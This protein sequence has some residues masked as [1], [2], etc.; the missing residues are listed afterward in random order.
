MNGVVGPGARPWPEHG[1]SRR[2]YVPVQPRLR[3]RT[4]LRSGAGNPTWYPLRDPTARF[5]YFAR[6]A[7]FAAVAA[8]ELRG[9]EVLVPAYHHGVEVQA[10]LSAGAAVRFYP[11]AADWEVRPDEVADLV[12]TRTAALYVTHFGGFAGPVAA[13]RE[14][15]DGRGFPLLEDCALALMS[16]D[17]GR[18]LGTTGDLAFFSLYK[19]LPVPDG[20]AVTGRPDVLARLPSFDRP[21]VASTAATVVASA[22]RGLEGRSG[23]VGRYV[24]DSVRMVGRRVT[25]LPQVERVSPGTDEFDDAHVGLGISPVSL[26]L[27]RREDAVTA[28]QRRRRNYTRLA[29]RLSR[30]ADVVRPELADDT[31]PLFYPL[32]VDDKTPIRQSLARAGVETVDFWR[33]A[34]PACP[35]GAFPAVERLRHTVVELPCHQDLDDSDI[36]HVAHAVEEALTR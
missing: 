18:P 14:L 30:V 36:D 31:C 15:A 22:L 23:A 11:V 3:A 9:R 12:T 34:H 29:S 28:V 26:T 19:S 32:V 20:G 16:G 17:E 5:V 24:A 25:E 1:I 21:P 4:L 7:V 13:F 27:A 6:N 10:L 8:L 33:H 35:P 2:R